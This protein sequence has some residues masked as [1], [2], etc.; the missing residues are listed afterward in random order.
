[1]SHSPAGTG[2]SNIVSVSVSPANSEN[3][4]FASLRLTSITWST[5]CSWMSTRPLRGWPSES[6]APALTSDS[7][8]RLLHTV[9]GTLRRKSAKLVNV[10]LDRR[11]ASIAS[12]TLMPTLRTAARPNLMSS[13]TGVKLAEEAFTSGGSTRMPIRRHSFRYSADLS[14]SPAMEVSRAAMY[15]AG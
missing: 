3:W 15:S 1:M 2:T 5:A 4:L 12:T 7:I 10:P 14:L 6:N 9:T 13:P 8:T 11:A